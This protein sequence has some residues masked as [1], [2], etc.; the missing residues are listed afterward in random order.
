MV[1][2]VCVWIGT[3][4]LGE[5]VTKGGLVLGLVKLRNK[6]GWEWGFWDRKWGI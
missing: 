6:D 2:Y 4:E 5:L 1:L 3:V